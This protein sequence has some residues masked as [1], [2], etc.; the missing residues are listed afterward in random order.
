MLLKPADRPRRTTQA[1]GRRRRGP[2]CRRVHLRRAAERS[3]FNPKWLTRPGEWLPVA[4]STQNDWLDQV[5]E[6]T[7]WPARPGGWLGLVADSA[8]W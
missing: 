8:R 6:S 3:M 1:Y 7:R 5:A 4:D 2:G